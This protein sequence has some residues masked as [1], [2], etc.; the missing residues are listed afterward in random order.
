M[1]I[2]CNHT[3]AVRNHTPNR[4]GAPDG[5]PAFLMGLFSWVDIRRELPPSKSGLQALSM[6]L[7]TECMRPSIALMKISNLLKP[8]D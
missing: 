1:K 2:N 3:M 6:K 4:V 7:R 8:P 5:L